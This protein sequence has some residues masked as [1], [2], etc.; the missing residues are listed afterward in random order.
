MKR[1]KYF[2][3]YVPKRAAFYNVCR[4]RKRAREPVTMAESN[5]SSENV[6]QTHESERN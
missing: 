5:L 6:I 4:K 3:S 2:G 1:S